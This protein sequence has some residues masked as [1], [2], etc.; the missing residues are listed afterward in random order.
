M[1]Y[2]QWIILYVGSG[3]CEIDI[4]IVDWKFKSRLIYSYKSYAFVDCILYYFHTLES[5]F[6]HIL[7][8]LLLSNHRNFVTE[9][10]WQLDFH[11]C[12]MRSKPVQPSVPGIRVPLTK[13]YEGQCSL[14]K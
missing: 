8:H 12:H 6:R 13:I 4:K 1:R 7:S 10:N 14:S 11:S 3:Y 5:T 2:F 9:G